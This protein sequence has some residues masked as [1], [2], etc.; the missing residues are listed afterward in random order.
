MQPFCICVIKMCMD[1]SKPHCISRTHIN[2][3]VGEG[4]GCGGEG[5]LENTHCCLQ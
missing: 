1:V 5:N 2:Q 4:L 3:S